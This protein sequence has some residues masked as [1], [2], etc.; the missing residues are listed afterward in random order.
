MRTSLL[1][2]ALTLVALS[3]TAQGTEVGFG[4]PEHDS[5]AP[6]EVVADQLD[7]QRS[8]GKAKFTGNVVVTQGLM[9]LF[10]D[11]VDVEYAENAEG[12]T[13]IQWVH[14]VG[15]VTLLNGVEAAEGD[16]AVYT[17]E[18]GLVVMTGDVLVTQGENT[19]AGEKLT[20]QLETGVGQMEGRVRVLFNPES[21]P[22][23]TE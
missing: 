12:D 10:G 4:N 16:D 13:E 19:M 21:E 18:S 11:V 3:A 1:G 7:V 23:T 5:S 15:N 22:E 9:K 20:V 2:I 17:V 14:A 8:E 6:V